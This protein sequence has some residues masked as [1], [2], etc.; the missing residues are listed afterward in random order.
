MSQLRPLLRAHAAYS[1]WATGQI[2]HVCSALQPA[3]IDR[4]FG[5]SHGS[6]L[7]TLRHVHDGERV[8]LRRLLNGDQNLPNTPAPEHSFEFLVQSWP[9]LWEGY[10]DWLDSASDADLNERILTILPNNGEF[11]VP[12]WQIILH[13][14]NHTSYHRGQ[15]VSM[16]RTLGVQPPN[17]DLTCY[18][19]WQ[20]AKSTN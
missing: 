15:I 14:I 7:G 11:F 19:A 18:Y 17:T 12:R 3:Q 10:R 4:G 6:I 1:A 5:A 20:R 16:L 13:V 9:S 2:L 8:W